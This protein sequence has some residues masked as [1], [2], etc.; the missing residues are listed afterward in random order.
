VSTEL[1]TWLGQILDQDESVA[2]AA[3]PG[4]WTWTEETPDAEWGALG[5]DLRGSE[6]DEYGRPK[7]VVFSYGHDQWGIEVSAEDQAHIA[8]W[9]PD[10]VLARIAVDRRLLSLHATWWGGGIPH[11]YCDT[12]SGEWPCATLRTLV[13]AY[14]DRPGYREEWKP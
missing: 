8:A 5:P 2:R 14:A 1:A 4:P 3:S 12:C 7:S 11:W 13:S 6:L 10:R 9:G